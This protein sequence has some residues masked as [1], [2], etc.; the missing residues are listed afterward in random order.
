MHALLIALTGLLSFTLAAKAPETT[1]APEL[2]KAQPLP[3]ASMGVPKEASLNAPA[4]VRV[5]GHYP[6]PSWQFDHWQMAQKGSTIEL[7]PFG[8]NL[9]RP[10]QMVAQVLVPYTLPKVLTG[11]RP[12][13]YTIVVNG[14]NKKVS[15]PLTIKESNVEK[16][17]PYIDDITVPASCPTGTQAKV[18]VEGNLPD[19][20]WKALSAEVK[21]GS[22]IVWIYPWGERNRSVFAAEVLKPHTWEVKLP[23]LPAGEYRVIVAGRDR[24]HTAPLTIAAPTDKPSAT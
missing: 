9:Q 13:K 8:R 3:V 6:T 17:F 5:T 14:K 7:T 16:G 24:E 15:A 22:G 19:M 18:T 10:D 21:V 2:G 4:T 12:G 11:L 1:K 20:G 23:V